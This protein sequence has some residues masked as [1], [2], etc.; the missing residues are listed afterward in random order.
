M[1]DQVRVRPLAAGDAA[2]WERLWR[3][4][5]RF[6][7]SEVAEAQYR[8]T[9]ARLLSDDPHDFR[10]LVAEQAGDAH[11]ARAL[12]LSSPRLAAGAGLLPAGPL[13]R[14]RKPRPRRRPAADRGGLRRGRRGRR[15]AGLVADPGVRTPPPG[16]S[17]TGSDDRPPSSATTGRCREPHRDPPHRSGARRGLRWPGGAGLG[18][19]RRGAGRRPAAAAPAAG[20]RGPATNPPERRDSGRYPRSGLTD[21]DRARGAQLTRFEGAV[22]I[23]IRGPAP[24]T[25][26]GGG[27]FALRPRPAHGGGGPRACRGDLQRRPR[28]F[29]R[30]ARDPA[31]RGAC[32]AAPGRLCARQRRAVPRARAGRG[33]R[34]GG[35]A[36]RERRASGKPPDGQG[37]GAGSAG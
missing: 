12:P 22:S 36:G 17:T 16:G 32:P 11:R 29:C 10:G 35:A 7:D 15:P 20:R 14:A 2:D 19:P 21:E 6:Y 9:F 34:P 3:D 23:S 1:A 31:A 24:F 26:R 13:C 33:R 4:Y 30:Q 37:R 18:Q 28:R 25:L 5:L 27:L 8:A